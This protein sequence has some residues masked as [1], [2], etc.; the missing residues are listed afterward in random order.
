MGRST[1]VVILAAGKGTRMRS[2]TP[3][4]LQPLCGRPMLGWVLDQALALDPVRIVVVIGHG[5]EKVEAYTREHVGDRSRVEFAVQ[6]PQRG[7]GHAV[8]CALP[9]LGDDADTA[10]VLYGDMPLLR[11]ESLEHLLSQH[12]DAGPRAMAI[13]VGEFEDPTAYGRI[14]RAEDGSVQETVEERDCTEEQRWITEVNLGIYAFDM[15]LLHENIGKLQDDNAQGEL[16]LTD[17]LG[18]SVQAGLPAIA[19]EI[20][21]V[22][23]GQGV[24]TLAQLAEVRWDLQA[25]IHEMHMANGVRIED[26]LTTYIDHGVTIGAGTLIQPCC[27]IR[28]GVTIGEGCEVGPFAHLRTGV[29]LENAS[30][31]GNFCEAK[32]STLGEGSK[33]KHLTYLGNA[34]VGK[35]ANIGAGT[36]FA[37]YDGKHKHETQ[38]GD[39][40]FIGSGTVIVA[41]NTIPA[42]STTGA[43]AVVTSSADIQPGEV[44]AGL[45][46]R[47]LRGADKKPSTD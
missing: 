34:I 38:V 39:G 44:W 47:R 11:P 24:N 28:G 31:L 35:K 25:R 16:Y 42:G 19:V 43:G 4:V 18:L 46:A 32:N 20:D 8:Q 37:N 23:E 17:M 13:M 6:E 3:K 36:V 5:S 7:T 29:V 26:P 2:A 9:G 22:G 15:G 27:V 33:A 10:V 1:S 21:D 40:A 41:P 14:V 45:P 12:A 30:V